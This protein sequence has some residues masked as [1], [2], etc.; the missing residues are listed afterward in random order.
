MIDGCFA[1]R[2]VHGK[3]AKTQKEVRL[4]GLCGS[5][6]TNALIQRLDASTLS[7]HGAAFGDWRPGYFSASNPPIACV[8][9]GKSPVTSDRTAVA[10]LVHVSIKDPIGVGSATIR[11]NGYARRTAFPITIEM[12]C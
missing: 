7:S 4:L 6:G 5:T 2:E 10:F 9:T 8:P 11:Q 1:T 12:S 3:R